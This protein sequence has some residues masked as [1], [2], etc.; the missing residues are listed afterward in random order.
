M[1]ITNVRKITVKPT[2]KFSFNGNMNA[3]AV[4]LAELEENNHMLI[5]GNVDG[6]MAIFKSEQL[7]RKC[8]NL[9]T[10]TSIAYGDVRNDN[11]KCIICI[12][13]EGFCHIFD[14]LAVEL[15]PIVSIPVPVNIIKVL[16]SDIN[17]DGKN[18]LVVAR[19]DR[20]LHVFQLVDSSFFRET[21]QYTFPAQLGSMAMISVEEERGRKSEVLPL[22]HVSQPDASIAVIQR[23]G[24]LNMQ[25]EITSAVTSELAGGSGRGNYA[26]CTM[27]GFIRIRKD[28][29]EYEFFFPCQFFCIEKFP[30]NDNRFSDCYAACSWDGMTFI[31]E[32]AERCVCF[33]VNS[34]I[35]AFTCG[36]YTLNGITKPSLIYVTFDDEIFLHHGPRIPLHIPDFL[37]ELKTSCN[38]F[39]EMEREEIKNL[40]ATKFFP[41]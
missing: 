41:Q 17:C 36:L 32:N 7:H 3:A 11:T 6:E 2:E 20:V 29:K 28:D 40:I 23:D 9:G 21:N 35:C 25:K 13:A 5:V 30:L 31:G 19:T 1:V 22:L 12:T 18:E 4:C 38:Q 10:I 8:S 14:Y 39:S 15:K 26:V 27:D 24:T 37:N 16:I 33:E 34:R